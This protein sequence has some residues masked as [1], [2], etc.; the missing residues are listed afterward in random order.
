VFTPV[1]RFCRILLLTCFALVSLNAGCHSTNAGTT[2]AG[3]AA[4]AKPG[5]TW[6][7]FAP[8]P[9]KKVQSPGDFI[10]QQRPSY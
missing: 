7:P 3:G 4:A 5:S 8:D 2:T 6:N 1:L 9:P 10:I